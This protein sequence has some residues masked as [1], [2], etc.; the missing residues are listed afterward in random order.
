MIRGAL[1]AATQHSQPV[2][3]KGLEAWHA[4]AKFGEDGLRLY[5]AD[6][7]IGYTGGKAA[8]LRRCVGSINLGCAFGH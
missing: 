8:D 3:T 6:T 4:M 1:S 2:H 7:W 5:A